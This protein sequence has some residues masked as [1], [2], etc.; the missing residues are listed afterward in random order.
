LAS[1]ADIYR[2]QEVARVEVVAIKKPPKA[3]KKPKKTPK[4]L[5]HSKAIV[6]V[7]TVNDIGPV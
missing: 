7:V 6:N 2:R 3:V 5:V 1:A 4:A